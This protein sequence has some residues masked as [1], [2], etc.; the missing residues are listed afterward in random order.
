[1][2]TAMLFQRLLQADNEDEVDELLKRE[3]YGLD[4]EAAWRPLGDMENNFS[5][6]GN[7][8]TEATAALVEKIIN[9]IDAMLMAECFR[10]GIDPE[11][12]QAPGTMNDA[13]ER[14]FDVRDGS[15]ANLSSAQQT[16]LAK[17]LH[18]VATG[19]KTSPC[20]LI[21]RY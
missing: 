5:V 1:M 8:Q 6:V 7:Q 19:E 17:K 21:R 20:Y 11:G 10:A 13:V 4:N 15:L 14:F 12:P 2:D 3:G 18:V 16:E 9:G